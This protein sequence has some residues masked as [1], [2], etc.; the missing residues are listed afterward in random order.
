MTTTDPIMDVKLQ[1]QTS[2]WRQI[3]E[4]YKRQ[5]A[6]NPRQNQ[7]EYVEDLM[8][9]GLRVKAGWL[10]GMDEDGS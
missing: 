3:Q 7:S 6:A 9:Q 8:I 2:R 5:K 10:L 1:L 4:A